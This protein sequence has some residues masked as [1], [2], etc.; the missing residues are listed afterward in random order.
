[1]GR[2]IVEALEG[3]VDTCCDLSLG[4]PA[5]LEPVFLCRNLVSLWHSV[6]AGNT[7]YFW[8]HHWPDDPG[9]RDRLLFCSI[10]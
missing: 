2:W 5:Q 3:A 1:M 9:E 8:P 7:F 10:Y 4:K 6:K